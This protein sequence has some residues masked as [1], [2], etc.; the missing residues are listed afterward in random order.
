MHFPC[1]AVAELKQDGLR[2]ESLKKKQQ[3]KKLLEIYDVDENIWFRILYKICQS[4][5][6]KI[7]S[8]LHIGEI[9][10]LFYETR[11]IN[12]HHFKLKWSRKIM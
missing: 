5:Q 4:S 12:L 8:I 9:I 7:H 10:V 2:H 6:K 11:C 3:T 1:H